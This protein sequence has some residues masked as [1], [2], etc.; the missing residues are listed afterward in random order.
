LLGLLA[1]QAQ[2]GPVT[3]TPSI[4]L[5]E[6]YNDNLLLDNANRRWDLI[7][8][9]SPAI[10]LYVTRPTYRLSAGYTFTAE[11]YERDTRLNNAFNHQSFLFTGS[12][13]PTRGLTLT[14]SDAFALD[15]DTNRTATTL[16]FASGRQ[17][18]WTNT[19]TPGLTWQMT[20]QTSLTLTATHTM[21]RFSGGG[22]GFDSD[23][24]AFQSTL[25]HALTPRLSGLLGYGFTYLDFQGGETSR[26]HTPTVGASYRLTPSLT[27]TVSGGPAMTDIA[28]ETSVTAAG[29]ASLVQT[30][31]FGSA[32]VGYTR[33]VSAAGGLG[34]TTDTQSVSG[35]FTLSGLQRGLFIIFSPLYSMAESVSRRERERVDVKALTL[36]LSVT[37]QIAEYVSVFGG[38]TFFEQRTGAGASREVDADQ[39]RVRIGLQFGY[40]INFD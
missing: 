28:G 16:G 7:T 26:T 8:A 27:G 2:R 9:A 11:Y 30:L 20:P 31:Q 5:S 22:G 12:A 18:S 14:A 34:G 33:A 38:Y 6:E 37:Y 23:T 15:R 13:E 19:F 29:S 3:L 36:N 17:D 4:A 25:G 35:V 39:T 32:T 24:Y 21:L 1:P 10:T 40:P